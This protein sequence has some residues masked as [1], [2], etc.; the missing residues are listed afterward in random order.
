MALED[1]AKVGQRKRFIEVELKD[2]VSAPDFSRAQVLKVLDV[3][4]AA[5]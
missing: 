2:R 1:A 5:N 4:Q 3:S